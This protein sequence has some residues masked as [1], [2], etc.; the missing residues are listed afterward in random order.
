MAA[1]GPFIVTEHINQRMPE[2]LKLTKAL[3]KE[4]IRAGSGPALDIAVV[5]HE[6][7]P[8]AVEFLNHVRKEV[9]GLLIVVGRVANQGELESQVWMGLHRAARSQQRHG[10]AQHQE[11]A[12][13]KQA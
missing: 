9:G 7:E 5:D 4:S 3:L 13:E 6:S 12:G 8:G 11:R 2:G 1:V 10:E